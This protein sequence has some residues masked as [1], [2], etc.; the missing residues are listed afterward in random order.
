MMLVFVFYMYCTVPRAILI[1][2]S[3]VLHVLFRAPFCLICKLCFCL[4][5]VKFCESALVVKS[6]S[7]SLRRAETSTRRK[8]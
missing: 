2:T 8:A 7:I 6:Q 4:R 3:I 5:L 1:L